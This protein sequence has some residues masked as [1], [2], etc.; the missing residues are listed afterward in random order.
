MTRNLYLT[1][2]QMR[3]LIYESQPRNMPSPFSVNL[4]TLFGYPLYFAPALFSD[5][6][7]LFVR[8]EYCG[9]QVCRCGAPKYSQAVPLEVGEGESVF[10]A[11]LN[12]LA[13]RDNED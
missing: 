1:Y 12:H 10:T 13:R 9:Q 8:C 6:V 2:D 5:R 11:V 3:Q 4:A 7:V